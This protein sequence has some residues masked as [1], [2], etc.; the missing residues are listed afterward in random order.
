MANLKEKAEAEFE[1]IEQAL[2]EM[3]AYTQLPNLS[4]L[5]LAGVATLIHNFYNGIENVLKQIFIARNIPLPA[6]D[7]WHKDLLNNAVENEIISLKA[8]EM[9]KE[10]LAFRH[11]FSHAYALDLYPQRIEPLVEKCEAI[12]LL[13][14]DEIN[15]HI[16]KMG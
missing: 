11:F 10:Y 16:D 6:G 3:P 4:I 15:K 7:A 2:N 5:E 13:F 12:Y 1:N 14:K 8:K 9:L